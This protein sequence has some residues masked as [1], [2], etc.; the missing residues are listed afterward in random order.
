MHVNVRKILYTFY[1]LTNNLLNIK[2]VYILHSINILNT[3]WKN[4]HKL[5]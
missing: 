1:L 3:R 5:N 4:F 2:I